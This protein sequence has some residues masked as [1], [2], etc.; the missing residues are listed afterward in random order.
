MKRFAIWTVSILI[1]SAG[2]VWFGFQWRNPPIDWNIMVSV[3]CGGG[4]YP[5]EAFRKVNDE[6]NAKIDALVGDYASRELFVAVIP[7][8]SGYRIRVAGNSG[9][10]LFDEPMKSHLTDWIGQRMDELQEQERKEAEQAGTGQPATRP[11]LKSEGS[12]KPQPE[13]EGR[14]R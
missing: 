11:V 5:K 14:S 3:T 7:D 9:S 8:I 13:A 6:M 10:K 1:A 2:G 4:N 12:D